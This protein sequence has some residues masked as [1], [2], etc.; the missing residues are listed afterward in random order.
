[1]KIIDNLSIKASWTLV[2]IAFSGLSTPPNGH[3]TGAGEQSLAA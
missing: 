1:M 2:L 3:K